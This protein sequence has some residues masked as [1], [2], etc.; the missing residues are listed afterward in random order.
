VGLGIATACGGPLRARA[1]DAGADY[2]RAIRIEG[3]H[4]IA[5]DA[6][7]P[8]LALHEAM[9]D[10]LA[11]DPYL[12]TVDTERIRAAYLKRGFF[13]VQVVPRVDH[14]DDHAQTVVFTITEGRRAVTRVEIAGLPPELSPARARALVALRDG[15]PFDYELYDAAKQPLL[16]LVQDAGYA[17]A[18]VDETAT[19]GPDKATVTARYQVQPRV[20]CTFGKVQVRVGCTGHLPAS[21]E[22]AVQ[23]RLRFATGDR[24]STSALEA[25]QAEIYDL[26]RFSAVTIGP[27]HCPGATADDAHGDAIDL[28]VEVAEANRHELHAG[29]GFGYEPLTYEARLRGGGSLV[30][31]ALPLMT[32]A[33][34]ARVAVTIPHNLAPDQLEPKVRGLVSLQYLDLLWPRLRGDIEVG[35]DYQTVEA[36]TWTGPHVRLGLGSPLGPRW[37]QLR[38]GWVLEYLTFSKLDPAVHPATSSDPGLAHALGLDLDRWQLRGAYQASLVADLRD[39]PIEPHRGVYADLRVT[40]GTRL[41][42]G[43]L[44]YVQV[45]P[46]L[47]GYISLG[48]VVLAARAR[49]GAIYGDVPVTERYYSGGTSGQRGFSERRLS[50]EAI[51]TTDDGK[52]HTQVIGGAGLIEAGVELRRQ[53]GTLGSLP[54]G[55]N[56]FL[57][58]GDVTYAAEQ[59]DPGN[60]HWAVGTGVWAK[61]VGDLKLRIDLGYRLNRQSSDRDTFANFAPHIGVG[62]VY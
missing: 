1:P 19:V 31:A 42:G 23:A 55:A 25:S 56:V 48:G 32:L 17:N 16:A 59:L 2:L 39:N 26:G 44:T 14:R 28:V 38:V 36:Y 43:D 6:L 15:A 58:G 49:V 35:A 61:L 24:Y 50:P 8:A 3:N 7:E 45:T 52:L 21:L 47:R 37:L 33:A 51:G 46:E 54:V 10:A 30:P 41:A 60:L 11:I 27:D 40:R 18:K 13:D 22:A 20:R 5:T 29:G 57:D 62:E 34:D 9:Q 53:L 4:A 12:L